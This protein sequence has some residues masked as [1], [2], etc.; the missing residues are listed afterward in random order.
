MKLRGRNL[1]EGDV[2]ALFYS[3]H[4]GHYEAHRGWPADTPESISD[5][6]H[7]E[8]GHFGEIG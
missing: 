4:S 6:T 1:Y 2:P 5:E 7:L 3:V 8:A